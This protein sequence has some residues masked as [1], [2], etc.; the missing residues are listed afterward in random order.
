MPVH[1]PETVRHLEQAEHNYRA[2]ERLRHDG[3]FPD[4]ALTALF[5]AGLQIVDAHAAQQRVTF[6]DH[7]ERMDY[8]SSELSAGVRRYRRLLDASRGTRYML[9][10]PSIRDLD[11][12]VADFRQLRA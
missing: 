1:L 3:E 4:W 9:W 5:Y 12:H 7:Q 8:V 10:R 2:Y 6:R 11:E